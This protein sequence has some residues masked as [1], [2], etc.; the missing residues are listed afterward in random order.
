MSISPY[1]TWVA[2]EVLT[3]ADLNASFLQIINN[4]RSLISP[5][6]ASLDMD[7]FELVMDADADSSITADTD[8]QID[9]R[10]GGVDGYAFTRQGLAFTTSELTIAS[11][12]VT[13]TRGN[14]SIDTEADAASDDLDTIT[15]AGAISGTFLTLRGESDARKVYV[16]V[17]GNV[18]HPCLLRADTPTR[19]YY[20]GTDW[21]LADRGW[22]LLD[23]QTAST[24]ATLDFVKGIGSA[25]D[26]YQFI[27]TNLLPATDNTAL[28][29][30]VTHDAADFEDDA[31]DYEQAQMVIVSSGTGWTTGTFSQG[32][33][34]LALTSAQGNAAGEGAVGTV[35]M[36]A[37]ASVANHHF[38]SDLQFFDQAGT[39]VKRY[40]T[41]VGAYNGA[42]TA[43]NGVRFLMNSGDIASGTI[44]LYGLRK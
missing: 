36:F 23:T 37:P 18:D 28:Y 1:K 24:S 38:K 26:A 25:Y 40:Y 19:F 3:A 16:T 42:T 20:D 32:A 11:G 9:V 5:L 13:P 10:V 21:K 15:V 41:T 7:G 34:Q 2:G 39:P 14:H 27:V 12:A 29:L 8:D 31:T 44:A 6:T 4:A 43:I 35:L 17:A 30:R 33:A 22:I